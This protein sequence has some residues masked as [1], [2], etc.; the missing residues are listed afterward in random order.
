[1]NKWRYSGYSA[2]LCINKALTDFVPIS[3]LHFS[4]HSSTI[5]FRLFSSKITLLFSINISCHK[6]Q[7]CREKLE[8][9]FSKKCRFSVWG[10]LQC[11]YLHIF[12]KYANT[13]YIPTEISSYSPFHLYRFWTTIQGVKTAKE[14]LKHSTMMV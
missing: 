10:Y 7:N 12:H 9:V 3:S 2:H 4:M 1:M 8:P 5:T 11:C 6:L 13:K 14:R